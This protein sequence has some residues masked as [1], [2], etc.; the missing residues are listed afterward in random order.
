MILDSS[1]SKILKILKEVMTM[2]KIFKDFIKEEKGQ[3]LVEW[4]LIL[5]LI[6]VVIIA[7][8]KTIGEKGNEKAN[9]IKRE[10]E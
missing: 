4:I 6:L 9:K 10:L 5:A 7:A 2:I 3:T 1:V 8:I